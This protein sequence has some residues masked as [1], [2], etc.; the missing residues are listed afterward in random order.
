MQKIWF[1]DIDGKL[2]GPFS[3]AQLKGISGLTPDTLV[4]REGFE[5]SLPIRSVPELR[6]VF[7]DPEPLH[8]E[9]EVP[10]PL[11]PAGVPSDEIA[12]DMRSTPP[13]WLLVVL[14]ALI[15]ILLFGM[16]K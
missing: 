13:F 7:E 14:V 6:E 15:L 3:V 8:P 9:P 16:F 12:I 4:W 5:K 1:I 11:V 2:N 10:G